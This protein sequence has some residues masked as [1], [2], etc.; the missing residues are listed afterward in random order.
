MAL[1]KCNYVVVYD[2]SPQV[3]TTSSLETVL[4]AAP[5]KNSDDAKR[6]ILFLS[7]FPDTQELK[8]FEV[9]EEELA[10]KRVE[11]AE[12]MARREEKRQ[13]K[14]GKELQEDAESQDTSI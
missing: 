1:A 13:A 12:T 3:Y 7:Y 8:V 10:Q 14:A 11:V 9:T 6:T 4:D 5:P 2:N